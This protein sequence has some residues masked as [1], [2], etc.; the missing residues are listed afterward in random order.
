[1]KASIRS[2]AGLI[3]ALRLAL[4][5]S[6]SDPEILKRLATF[7][8]DTERLQAGLALLHEAETALHAQQ[9]AIGAQQHITTLQGE[10]FRKARIAYQ[11]LATL[12]RTIFK[13]NSGELKS[14]SL[15]RPMSRSTAG[16]ILQA[17]TLFDNA[18]HFE[19]SRNKLQE[20]GYDENRLQTEFA[21]VRSFIEIEHQQEAAKGTAQVSTVAK[22]TAFRRLRKYYGQFR[23]IARI[24]LRETPQLLEMLGI[25][26]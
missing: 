12:A 9:A 24:A 21:H 23:R 11:N 13:A 7:G 1:M 14:L 18:L 16:F 6:I 15:D 3:S 8:Y 22:Q 4:E 2:S 5:N 20:Y 19:E 25:A 10:H 26:A 17:R